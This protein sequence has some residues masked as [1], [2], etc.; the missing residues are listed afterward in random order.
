ME[1]SSSDDLQ[2][3]LACSHSNKIN[4]TNY[5]VD[6][7]AYDD[8]TVQQSLLERKKVM[9]PSQDPEIHSPPQKCVW[10]MKEVELTGMGLCSGATAHGPPMCLQVTPS[11]LF[12]HKAE[13]DSSLG[14]SVPSLLEINR[15][16]SVF[17]PR[18]I[19]KQV[20]NI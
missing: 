5:T 13:L 15:C 1:Q 11:N 19:I 14:L 9:I 2:E 6:S 16:F 20:Y 18:N 17:S 8:S 4:R 3:N 12:T 7:W 10:L